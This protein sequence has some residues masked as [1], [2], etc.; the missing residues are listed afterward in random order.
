MA[1]YIQGLGNISPQ[2]TY[3]PA[4]F[5][6]EFLDKEGT[7]LE[8]EKPDY[9]EFINPRAAR[10]MSSIVKMG[11]TAAK[12]CLADSGVEMPDAIITASGMGCREDTQNFMKS[13][14]QYE[15]DFVSP[16]AF[17]QSTHNTVGARIAL[18]LG[19]NNYNFT[20]VNRGF[21]FESTLLDGIMQIEEEQLQNI[22]IG[23]ADELTPDSRAIA[24]KI[25][26]V[27]SAPAR[28]SQ[29]FSQPA[30][31]Y[32]LGEGAAFMMLSKEKTDNT[33]AE[34][35][36]VK[37]LFNP[38]N[39]EVIGQHALSFLSQNGLEASDVDLMIT[40]MNGDAS[41]D[42]VYQDIIKEHFS[43]TPI[44]TYKQFS[45]E[46]YTASTFATWMAALILKEQTLP[47]GSM[48]SE[49]KPEGTIKNILIHSHI[50]KKYHSF[51]LL[52][53]VDR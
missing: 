32:M 11:V 44:A 35:K 12:I 2:K 14:D 10:R 42:Q 15:M 49:N 31:G 36:Q 43:A 39:A 50:G 48:Y 8:H 52:S 13:I 23:S 33:Y 34:I 30:K 1:V 24:E 5:L 45:G 20:Y 47:A 28:V 21:S 40:G 41:E 37:T 16:T 53:K 18:V 9:N 51:F 4:S 6:T 3:D 17:I 19:C 27:R 22:L 29:L 26:W 25:G 38:E 46:Y 7:W